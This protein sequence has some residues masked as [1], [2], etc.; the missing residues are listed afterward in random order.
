M[1]T[2]QKL[3]QI[4]PTAINKI[5][6]S[7]VNPEFSMLPQGDTMRGVS[8]ISHLLPESGP[9][10][11]S[12][13]QTKQDLEKVVSETLENFPDPGKGLTFT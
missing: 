5:I 13:F 1:D 10:E 2:F 12:I 4:E 7:Q 8:S 6:P 11:D 3:N 9:K